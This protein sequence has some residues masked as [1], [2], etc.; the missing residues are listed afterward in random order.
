MGD[1][2]VDDQGRRAIYAWIDAN[3]PYYGTW[4]MSRP[5]TVG[6]RDAYAKTLPG[7]GPVFASGGDGKNLSSFQPWV[8]KFDDF[9]TRSNKKIRKIS[10]GGSNER[11]RINL[12]RPQASPVLLNLLA[13]SAGGR[14][15]GDN[16][17]FQSKDDPNY[18]EL[19][20]ILKEAKHAVDRTPRMDMRAAKPSIRNGTSDGHFE[21]RPMRSS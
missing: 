2:K 12:T 7:K 10:R 20:T 17:Y 3:V 9:A 5:H 11:G 21:T 18:I 1:V 6:G 4:D 14:A 13:K 19:L 16:I 15:I 8:K